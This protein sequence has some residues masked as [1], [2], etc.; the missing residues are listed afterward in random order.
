MHDGLASA[1]GCALGLRGW[2][3]LRV[4]RLSSNQQ[5]LGLGDE[6]GHNLRSSLP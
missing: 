1:V 4:P 2:R 6:L 5:A 3:R